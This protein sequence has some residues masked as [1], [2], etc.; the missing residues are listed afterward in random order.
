MTSMQT[1][2]LVTV[3]SVGMVSVLL[4]MLFAPCVAYVARRFGVVD[5]PGEARKIHTRPTPLLGGW[6]LYLAVAC[7]LI[8][9][10]AFTSRLTGGEVTEMHYIGFLLGGLI[11]VVIGALD[12]RFNLPPRLTIFA[13]VLAALIAVIFGTEVEKLTNPLGGVFYLSSVASNIL[14][15]GWLLTVM[16]TTKMLD[17][18]DGLSTSIS[19][20]G[21]FMVLLLTL[22]TAYFQP[23]VSVFSAVILGSFLG[24]LFWNRH[25]ASIFLG[26]GG[27]TFVG[28]A[29]GMLAVI[30][31][32]KLAT[33][34]LVLGIPLL[35]VAW[36]VLRR[37]RVGGFR[38]IVKGDRKHLH[39][40]L[41]DLGWSQNRIV[42]AYSAFALLFGG[43]ALFLQSREKLIALILLGVCMLAT[44]FALVREEYA[45]TS[46]S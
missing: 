37:W 41:L 34:L 40:R 10:L 19:S 23:D 7:V 35:D 28:Y 16:Y 27:S 5:R 43:S 38:Q 11:L 24:F 1:D 31:G 17:G 36:V 14:V 21:V 12:D 29:V 20:I 42:F 46:R 22:T 45:T 8:P 3:L 26:E 44:A 15:F 39:H 6:A 25:P 13:P 4:A 9:L 30:S 32:G 33:A 18:L 2:I